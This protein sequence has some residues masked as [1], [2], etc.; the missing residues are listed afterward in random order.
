MTDTT[1]ELDGRFAE[2]V[3]RLREGN[4]WSKAEFVRILNDAGWT[5][6]HQTTLTRLE[7]GQ[8]APRLGEANLIAKVFRTSIDAMLLPPSQAG[9]E[10]DLESWSKL[11]RRAY[12]LLVGSTAEF[13]TNHGS[14]QDV[15]AEAGEQFRELKRIDAE[16]RSIARL[17]LAIQRAQAHLDLTLDQAREAG[18][19]A[20]EDGNNVPDHQDLYLLDADYP[21]I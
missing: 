2:N 5:Q 12:N 7:S 17:D 19:S 6:A 9:I 10:D 15:V 4:G 13:A 8:R 11:V 1:G 14:L 21:G 3:R 16:D 20:Y 18:L